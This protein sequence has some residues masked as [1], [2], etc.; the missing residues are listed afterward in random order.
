MSGADWA[1][2]VLILGYCAWL[3]FRPKKKKSGCCGNCSQCSGC[4]ER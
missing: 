1:L 4:H 2:V 3:I